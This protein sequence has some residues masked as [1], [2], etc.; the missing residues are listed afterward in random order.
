M[1]LIVVHAKHIYFC[2]DILFCCVLSSVLKGLRHW[3]RVLLDNYNVWIL[4]SLLRLFAL[5]PLDLNAVDLHTIVQDF[6]ILHLLCER[7]DMDDAS[8]PLILI[9]K[10]TLVDRFMLEQRCKAQ[11]R[12]RRLSTSVLI[13]GRWIRGFDFVYFLLFVF[14]C[15]TCSLV[16]TKQWECL[17]PVAGFFVERCEVF[18]TDF[19]M[20]RFPVSFGQTLATNIFVD[21]LLQD[22][23]LYSDSIFERQVLVFLRRRL[24]L[25][26][27]SL[28]L[29]Y[30]VFQ[31]LGSQLIVLFWKYLIDKLDNLLLAVFWRDLV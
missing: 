15:Y 5:K 20:T 27:F 11:Y 12:R 1:V 24:H 8:P 23:L 28:K 17:F 18:L 30:H 16:I 9:A 25:S 13:E 26:H 29:F 3:Y 22:G 21:L 10:F 6:W 7:L 14:R 19:I 31:I 4:L 2:V